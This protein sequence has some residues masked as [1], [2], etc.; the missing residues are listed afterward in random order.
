MFLFRCIC[1][2]HDAIYV[3]SCRGCGV[4]FM[5]TGFV[6]V[7]QFVPRLNTNDDAQTFESRNEE[8]LLN[9][10]R[11]CNMELHISAI[12]LQLSVRF[13]KMSVNMRIFFRWYSVVLPLGRDFPP[14]Q[15]GPGAHPASWG[16]PSLL[17]NGYRVF[18]GGKVRPGRAAD[19]SPLLVPSSWKVELYLYP[20]SGPQPGL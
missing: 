15:T 4:G 13:I 10:V 1:H 11:H 19:H 3:F 7:I 14:V 6:V 16:P 2:I 12:A 17:Y 18:P 20:P 9:C 5:Y 8:C